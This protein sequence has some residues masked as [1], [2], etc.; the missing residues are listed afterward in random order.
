MGKGVEK[1]H[2]KI[3]LYGDYIRWTSGYA[4]EFRD[5]LPYFLKAGHEVRQVALGYNG[6]PAE[7]EIQVYH[8]K[9]PDVKDYYAQEVLHY[10]IDDF[11]LILF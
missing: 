7:K 9:L 5:V 3:L 8:T 1:K 10:A 4:R 11:K 2:M 6:F